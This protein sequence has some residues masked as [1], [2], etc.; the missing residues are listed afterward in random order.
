MPAAAGQSVPSWFRQA[1]LITRVRYPG[2]VSRPNLPGQLQVNTL[3]TDRGDS[4]NGA[5][6]IREPITPIAAVNVSFL[7]RW[8]NE[9]H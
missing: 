8:Q 7:N 9:C 1:Q 4:I 5:T 3:S 2:G 6:S